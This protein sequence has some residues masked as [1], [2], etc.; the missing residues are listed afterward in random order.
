M[1][2]QVCTRPALAR[3]GLSA[4]LSGLARKV[5][6]KRRPPQCLGSGS[7]LLRGRPI[8]QRGFGL[9]R[10]EIKELGVCALTFDSSGRPVRDDTA[11][12]AGFLRIGRSFGSAVDNIQQMAREH[13]HFD[14]FDSF[15]RDVPVTMRV[16]VGTNGTGEQVH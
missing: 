1:F 16:L 8:P 5:S 13:D 12:K 6:L 11:Q 9:L 4:E 10:A 2:A 3:C 15:D 7:S 14:G